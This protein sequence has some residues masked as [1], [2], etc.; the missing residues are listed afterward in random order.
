[1]INLFQ[2]YNQDAWDIHYTQLRQGK[3]S[4][5]IV[6]EDDGFLPSDVDSI[7][8]F[9]GYNTCE[10]NPLHLNDL[11]LPLAYEVERE[12]ADFFIMS[13]DR[14]VGKVLLYGEP[15]E[16][17]VKEVWWLDSK[18]Y[19]YKKD[20]YNQYG[21]CFKVETYVTDLGLVSTSYYSVSGEVLLDENHLVGSILYNNQLYLNK[22]SLYN[23]CLAELGYSKE[24]IT[25]NHLG[26]P[27]EIVLSSLESGHKLIFQ[28]EISATSIPENLQYVINN[29]DL[30]KISISVTNRT[31]YSILENMCKVQF[32][33]L[34]VPSKSELGS[35]NEVLITTQTDQLTSVEDFVEQLP[36][37]EFHIAAPTQMSSKLLVL[38][39]HSNV[40]LYP[41]V[42]S[43]NLV[44]LFNRCGLFLDIAMSPTVFNANRRALENNLLR[45]GLIGVSTGKYISDDNLFSLKSLDIL[46]DYLRK[47]TSKKEELQNVVLQENLDLG[48]KMDI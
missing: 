27:L 36:D 11:T 47:V 31:T 46:I 22:L 8:H 32:M 44:D 28:E 38:N 26:T 33:M 1:M 17:I 6:I 2:T 23:K 4:P 39:K 34:L 35:V 18:G 40:H 29:L 10:Y 7:Y 45:V 48:F 25:F 42:S 37:L 3:D 14:V 5:T 19:P 21:Y 15:I 13:N 12:G 43:A 16:R 41:N 20:Y 9:L 30:D 24:P